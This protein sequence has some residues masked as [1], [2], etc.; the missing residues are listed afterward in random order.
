MP[1]VD[2]YEFSAIPPR[3]A[4]VFPAILVRRARPLLSPRSALLYRA[5]DLT[6]PNSEVHTISNPIRVSIRRRIRDVTS[7]TSRA[8]VATRRTFT[9][10]DYRS[11]IR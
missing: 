11:F 2:I 10:A 7:I 9:T 6:C 4:A 1:R 5:L 3:P 8:I